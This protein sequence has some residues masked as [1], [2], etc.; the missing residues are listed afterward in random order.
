MRTFSEKTL[1]SL[2]KNQNI[3]AFNEL[4]SRYCKE[5]YDAAY[6]RLLSKD[7]V[8]DIIQDIFIS[9]WNNAE[10][11]DENLSLR[12]YLFK[13]LKYK[14]IDAIYKNKSNAHLSLTDIGEI[15]FIKESHDPLLAKEL[16]T[17]LNNEID[18]LPVKMK[19][20]FLL[21]RKHYLPND[22]IAKQLSISS[23]TVKNQI[24]MALKRLRES[25]EN[26][27]IL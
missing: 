5:L 27:N 4:Y 23:Q 14:V 11:L 13:S 9:I 24:S 22:E 8:Q 10:N 6:K 17:F 2:L 20:V 15:D 12:P 1:I 25:L 19:Q 7:D 21:S 16:E 3:P 26:A 18:N